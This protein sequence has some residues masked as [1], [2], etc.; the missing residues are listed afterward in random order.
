V[1]GESGVGKTTLASTLKGKTLIISSESGLMSLKDT[2]IDFVDINVDDNGE[3]LDVEG[4]VKRLHELCNDLKKKRE[5][6]ERYDNIF[7]DSITDMADLIQKHSENKEKDNKNSYA[8]WS[9]YKK[10]FTNFIHDFRDIP[11][12]NVVFVALAAQDGDEGSKTFGKWL[13]SVIGRVARDRVL[14]PSLDE[15]Y[16]YVQN[17][18]NERIIVTQNT[19]KSIAKNR[20]KGLETVEKPDLQAIFDKIIKKENK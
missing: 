6:R 12:Y 4:K 7:L 8:Q 11:F 20:S 3:M 15:I 13:P 18:N 14:R 2:D 16:F 17:E 5:Y 1:Y 10:Y 9:T 19:N